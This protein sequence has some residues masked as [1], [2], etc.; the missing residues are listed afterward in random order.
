MKIFFNFQDFYGFNL[1]RFWD[2][3]EIFKDFED[4]FFEIFG[5]VYEI[6]SSGAPLGDQDA[7]R[8]CVFKRDNGTNVFA[9]R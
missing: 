5:K 6:F 2:F 1:I 4:F 9:N 7:K 8:W 3:L